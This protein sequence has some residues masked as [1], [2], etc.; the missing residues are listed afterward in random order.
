MLEQLLHHIKPAARQLKCK[1]AVQLD[2]VVAN[3]APVYW[4]NKSSVSLNNYRSQPLLITSA[5]ESISSSI[6]SGFEKELFS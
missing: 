2:T 1:P 4:Q 3:F 6:I 5:T